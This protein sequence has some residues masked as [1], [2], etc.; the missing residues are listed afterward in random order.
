MS[1]A[2]F[3][4]ALVGDLIYNLRFKSKT[5]RFEMPVILITEKATKSQ[6]HEMLVS[7]DAYI[8]MAV[9]VERGVLAGGGRLHSDCESVLLENG[10]KQE[11]VWGAD[12][13]PFA[14][15]VTFESLINVRPRQNNLTMKVTDSDL[16]TKIERVVRDLLEG[17][18]YE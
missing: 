13:L 11:N 2:N 1:A 4:V 17:V 3:H 15:T 7:L 14:S 16:K 18:E 9:D 12:W 6:M 8:K 5:P 10:S